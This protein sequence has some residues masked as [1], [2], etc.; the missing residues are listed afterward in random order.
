MK[1][2]AI[3]SISTRRGTYLP[4]EVF[5]MEDGLAQKL[6]DIGAIETVE[7][8][9]IQTKDFGKK[10]KKLNVDELK[11]LAQIIDL[12]MGDAKKD[13]IIEL[14]V[15]RIPQSD[16]KDLEDLSVQEIKAYLGE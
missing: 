6:I 12:D 11:Q 9:R 10:L 2:K 3:K 4:G 15:E 13:K 7:L 1:V 5:E 16:L 14:L 8:Q